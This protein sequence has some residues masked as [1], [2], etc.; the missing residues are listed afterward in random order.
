MKFKILILVGTI[1]VISLIA[2]VFSTSNVQINKKEFVLYENGKLTINDYNLIKSNPNDTIIASTNIGFEI[3][4]YEINIVN[5]NPCEYQILSYE[6]KTHFA[7]A[8][9]WMDIEKAE[10]IGIQTVLNH[11]QRHFDIYQIYTKIINFEVNA[12]FTG[13]NFPCAQVDGDALEVANLQN[14]RNMIIPIEISVQNMVNFVQEKYE[15][16]TGFAGDPNNKQNVWD[17]KIDKCLSYET[18]EEL[19]KCYNLYE[20]KFD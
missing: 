3:P 8:S 11:E 10:K 6:T 19:Q 5:E 18:R 14:A 16:E 20:F 2:F 4:S 13:R 12:E 15:M 17:K 1:I 9:T 7:P